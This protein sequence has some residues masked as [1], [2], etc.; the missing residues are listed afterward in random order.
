MTDDERQESMSGRYYAPTG[1]LPAQTQLTTDRA[2]FTEA[3]AVLPRGTMTDIVTSRLP[4]WEDTR[5][6]VIARPL[7]GFAETFSQYIVEVSPGGGSDRP[8]PDPDA[9]GVLFVVGGELEVTIEG[10]G[11]VMGE[12]GYAFVPPGATWTVRNGGQEPARFH[13]IRKSYERVEGIEAPEPFVTNE[14]DVEPVPM[15]D[16][17]GAWTTTRF[18]DV[19]DIRHDMH[20]NIVN[21]EPGGAIPFP[22]THVMEHGLY[23][24]EGKAVYLLNKDWVE[25][26]EGDFMWLR[27]FCPQACYAGGPGRFRYLLYKDVNRHAKLGRAGL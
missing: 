26:Q 23:V 25:V 14:R 2:V 9:E 19:D 22:E 15:P 21:F 8:E 7:S 10:D 27:A 4:H 6:W 3:Y 11:H 12:G 5:L 1:G 20:V 17:N 13:W 16:T 18:V 24:L